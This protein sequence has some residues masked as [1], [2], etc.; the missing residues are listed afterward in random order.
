MVFTSTCPRMKLYKEELSRLESEL[1]QL[2]LDTP[3]IYNKANKAIALCRDSLEIMRERVLKKGF[4]DTEA[5]CLFFKT[6]KPKVVGYLIHY[7]NLVEI[8]HHRPI[9]SGKAEH[10]FY[11]H[12]IATLRNYFVEH[13]EFYEYYIRGIS[14]YDLSFFT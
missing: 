7:V 12:Q 2:E 5:E 1:E 6:I 14:H 8:E 3:I 9:G 13:R 10:R 11:I 4:K